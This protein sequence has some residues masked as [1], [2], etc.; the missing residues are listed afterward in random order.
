MLSIRNR[1]WKKAYPGTSRQEINENIR[2]WTIEL[3]HPL[4]SVSSFGITILENETSKSAE[5]G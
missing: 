1:S 4:L 3:I 5:E 2:T